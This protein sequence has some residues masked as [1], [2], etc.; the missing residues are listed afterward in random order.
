MKGLMYQNY[1]NISILFWE[2]LLAWAMADDRIPLL[3]FC[4]FSKIHLRLKAQRVTQINSPCASQ[5]PR[6]LGQLTNSAP[7]CC[8]VEGYLSPPSLHCAQWTESV[9]PT[10]RGNEER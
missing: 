7:V 3:Q 6:P 1:C 4:A 2:I 5:L 9:Q 10:A 8:S